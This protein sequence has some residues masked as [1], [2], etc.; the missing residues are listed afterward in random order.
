MAGVAAGNA[1]DARPVFYART[2]TRRRGGY[3]HELVMRQPSVP[4]V[5][6]RLR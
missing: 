2:A 6:R 3:G 5:F 1:H 4:C